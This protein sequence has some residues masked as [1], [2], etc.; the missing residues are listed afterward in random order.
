MFKNHFKIAFRHLAKHKGFSLINIGG[1]AVSMAVAFLIVQYLNFEMGH[2]QFHK[3][4]D[5]IFRVTYQQHENG[6]LK[7]TSAGTF[8]GVGTFVQENF[9]QVKEVVR[10]YKWP[11]NTGVL[12][13]AQNKIYNERNYFFAEQSFF[14]VFPSL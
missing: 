5:E 1:L 10:F 12:I 11:A 4:S 2:D 6:E 13:M 3:N 7:N 14:K 9:P 8:Y